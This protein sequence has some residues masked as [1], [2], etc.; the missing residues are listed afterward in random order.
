MGSHVDTPEWQSFER[1]MRQRYGARRRRRRLR[2]AAVTILAMVFG[3]LTLPQQGDRPIEPAAPGAADSADAAAT[4]AADPDSSAPLDEPAPAVGVTRTAV[5]PTVITEQLPPE[6]TGEGDT[7]AAV[8]PAATGKPAAAIEPTGGVVT[9]PAVPAASPAVPDPPRAA[10]A[11]PERLPEPRPPAR[12]EPKAEA[13][14]PDPVPTVSSPPPAPMAAVPPVKTNEDV[15]NVIERYRAAYE[16]LDAA[17]AQ[18]V[19]PGVDRAALARAFDGLTSQRIEFDRCD[20]WRDAQAAL[21]SC[22]GRASYV[23]KVG[24]ALN[25]VRREWHFRLRRR[26]GGWAIESAEVR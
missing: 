8:E 13:A 14:K 2:W 15:R 26:P 9:K 4:G 6:E 5:T 3:F 10:L 17:A 21:A 16:Q 11:P 1:K 23:P 12:P 20:I 18:A 19:W 22:A 24:S 25:S 7:A